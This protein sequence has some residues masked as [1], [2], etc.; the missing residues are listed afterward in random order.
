MLDLTHFDELLSDADIVFTG[1]GRFDRQ[2]LMGKAVG[3]IASRSKKAGVLV[4][5]V[6]GAVDED[7]EGAY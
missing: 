7:V 2:S 5:C 4:V 1:E 6:A 3:D